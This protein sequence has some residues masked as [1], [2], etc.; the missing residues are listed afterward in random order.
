MKKLLLLALLTMSVYAN[1]VQVFAGLSMGFG[2]P[3]S[4]DKM[5]DPH[6]RFG[7]RYV[8]EYVELEASHLSAIPNAFDKWGINMIG[9]N[10]VTP[11][12]K[13]FTGFLGYA[14]NMTKG[15]DYID[16]FDDNLYR[17][18]IR[19]D[20]GNQRLF[21]EGIK[22]PTTNMSSFGVEWLF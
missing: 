20:L 2:K 15:C 18:G 19:Y 12:Y 10:S 17:V 1:E 5:Y 4:E 16:D 6:G 11:E 7:V 13:G 21:V 3:V 22:T 8:T 14:R 9:I